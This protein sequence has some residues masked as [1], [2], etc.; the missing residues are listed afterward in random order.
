MFS[1]LPPGFPAVPLYFSHTSVVPGPSQ[2]RA[3]AIYAR[4]S[5]HAQFTDFA[6]PFPLCGAVL[7]PPFLRFCERPVFPH[8]TLTCV[9]SFPPAEL[10]AFSGTTKPSDS[11]CMILPSSLLKEDNTGS[12]GCPC[13]P[14]VRHDMV[15]DPGEANIV[16]PLTSM[17]VLTSTSIKVLSF[18]MRRLRGSI[19]STFR[20]TAYLLA[21]LRLKS[22]VTTK[23]P[24]TRYP[25]AGLPSGTGFAPA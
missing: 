22:D 17:F 15:S 18:P 6:S 1:L 13:N 3:C 10:P 23:P 4:G 19:P 14:N 5:S 12:P 11:L 21:V 16:L 25:A 9:A 24:G 20:L 2:N 8:T 7:L